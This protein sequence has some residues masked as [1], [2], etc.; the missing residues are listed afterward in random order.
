MPPVRSSQSPCRGTPHLR[1]L[2]SPHR[3]CWPSRVI[4]TLASLPRGLDIDRATQA[5]KLRAARSRTFGLIR[6]RP[7]VDIRRPRCRPQARFPAI[8][9]RK[10]T[11]LSTTTGGGR[12]GLAP[13]CDAVIVVGSPKA[14]IPRLVEVAARAGARRLCWCS[15]GADIPWSTGNRHAWS[16][17]RRFRP[18]VAR[19]RIIDA[20]RAAS[21]S[22]RA[23][24]TRKNALPSTS[25]PNCSK[26][27]PPIRPSDPTLQWR[28]TLKSE[29]TWPRSRQLLPGALLASRSRRLRNTTILPTE[30]PFFLTLYEKRVA[31]DDLPFFLCLMSIS[32]SGHQ[33]PDAVPTRKG[34]V[35]STLA[36]ARRA[37]SSSRCMDQSP[38]PGT[39]WRGARPCPSPGRKASAS[40]PN[41]WC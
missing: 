11:R 38:A 10:E 21:M 2:R 8:V 23:V 33:L 3:P 9:D 35:L 4:G 34:R 40:A 30:R 17:R 1:G 39:A 15:S 16:H 31:P 22:R 18:G 20:F 36:A 29:T 12:K 28:S 41:A 19:P 26:P 25:A 37:R 13:R 7:P 14:R 6:R 32:A 27:P 24:V 5:L